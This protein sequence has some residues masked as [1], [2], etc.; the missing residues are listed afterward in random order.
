MVTQWYDPETASAVVPGIIARS[1]HDRGHEIDVLTGIPNFPSG[2]VHSN[3]HI[4]PY[5]RET[6]QGITVHRAPL[7]PSHDPR[8]LKRVANYLSFATSASAVGLRALRDVDALLVYSTP[9]T[10]ALPAMVMRAVRG[11]PYVLFVP[12]LW[13]QTV[14]ATDLVRPATSAHLERVLHHFCDAVYSRA[15]SIVVTSPGMVDLIVARGVDPEK[16]SVVTN[17]VDEGAFFPSPPDADFAKNLDSDREFT[18]MYAG[19]FGAAQGLEVVMEAAA[20]LRDRRDVGFV[21]VGSGVAERGLRDMVTKLRLDNVRFVG[22]Q[23]MSEMAGV[24]SHGDIQLVS[25]R[26]APLFRTT[27]PSKVQATMAAGRPIIGVV[28]GDAADVIVESGTGVAVPPGDSG[29]LADAI[30]AACALTTSELN[31]RGAN[32]RDYYLKNMSQ[33]VNSERLS[34]LLE[35]AS[36]MRAPG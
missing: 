12:D 11:I 21:M 9:A 17:W 29:A 34:L 1:L 20:L 22:P 6:L 33:H 36:N 14:T 35:T 3:Y 19:N 26:D 24:L 10:V 18:V 31:A 30:R 4:R 32:G 16:I 13:P 8:A 2:N 5:Q 15:S 28:S 7:Y 25:L 23:P 27:M